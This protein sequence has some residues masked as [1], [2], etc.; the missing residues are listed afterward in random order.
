MT[1]LSKTVALI[2]GGGSGL[3]AAAAKQLIRHG[4]RVCIADVMSSI[5]RKDEEWWYQEIL[6]TKTPLEDTSVSNDPISTLGK[7]I[8]IENGQFHTTTGPA[9]TYSTTDITNTTQIIAALNHIEH[10]FGEP[11]NTVI[12]CAGIANARRIISKKGEPHPIDDFIQTMMVN[13]V[14]TFNVNRLAAQRMIARTKTTEDNDEL[15]GCIINTASIAA[16]EGQIG[17]VAYAASKGA[18]V[19]MTLPMARDLA[20]YKIRVMTIVSDIIHPFI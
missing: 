1:L 10:V 16:Y 3:G 11:V 4:A 19:A 17:Q 18:I 14:G 12:N 5:H 2:T 7:P 20:S 9:I 6:K 15:N 13:T 8:V